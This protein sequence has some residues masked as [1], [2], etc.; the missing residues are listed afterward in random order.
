MRLRLLKFHAILIVIGA[1]FMNGCSI[2]GFIERLSAS[3][4][5]NKPL[6]MQQ[7]E[8]LYEK[9]FHSSIIDSK[10]ASLQGRPPGLRELPRDS[11]GEINWTAAVMQG[12]LAPK[13]TLGADIEA[14]EEPY[15]LNIFIKAVTP[16]MSDVIFPH[17]IHTYWHSCNNCHP[18]IFIPV[19]GANPISMEEI[20]KGE[21]CGQCHGKV[22]FEFWP[23]GNCR[24]CHMATKGGQ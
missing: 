20:F 24:R 17:S 3:S 1:F 10:Y 14:E 4:P 15:N 6:T 12:L 16:L 9:Y 23:E 18:K 13:G 22:A 19:A 21:W 11:H 7:E 2:N 5:R 8:I